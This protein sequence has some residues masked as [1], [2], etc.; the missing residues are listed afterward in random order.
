MKRNLLTL[1]LLFA[2]SILAGCGEM[3]PTS[4]PTAPAAGPSAEGKHLVLA[5]AP[6]S[7]QNVIE[8][9]EH[10]HA[11]E[12]IVVVGRIGGDQNPWVEGMAAFSIVD[13]SLKACSEIPGDTCPT[14][15]DYCCEAG[16]PKSRTLVK[17]V[18]PDGKVIDTDARQLLGVSELQTVYVK[19]RAQRDADGN[20]TVL[21]N[22]VYIAPATAAPAPTE[23]AGGHDHGH[24]HAGHDHA[25][26]HTETASPGGDLTTPQTTTHETGT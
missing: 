20:L 2:A 26:E 9:R 21:A 6:A 11:D 15:W 23:R 3:T 8:A 10:A 17:F 7:A 25:H 13:R 16:L 19:G 4:S 12:D 14:P 22:N 1:T 24:E 18:G 5:E